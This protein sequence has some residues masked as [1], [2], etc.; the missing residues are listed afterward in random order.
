MAD[1]PCHLQ[2]EHIG[3]DFPGVTALDDVTFGVPAGR[4][5]ALVGENGAGKSTLLKILSG[6]HPPS[7]GTVLIGG[8]ACRFRGAADAFR[9]GVAVI[10]QELHL[11]PGLS[12]AENIFLGRLRRH[13]RP[14]RHLP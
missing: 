7:R 8:Q 12:V 4:V 5:H 2:F 14:A 10:Y 11:V 9:A 6:A 1:R 13:L 3:K